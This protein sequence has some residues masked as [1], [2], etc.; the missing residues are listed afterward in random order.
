MAYINI[1]LLDLY[2]SNLVLGS[3][4]GAN[5]LQ[6][7]RNL[8]L[9]QNSQLMVS[10]KGIQC[11]DACAVRESLACLVKM[12]LGNLRLVVS[13][14]ENIDVL[15][16]L[17]LGFN[18][19]NLPLVTIDSSN[20]VSIYTNG[21]SVP[22]KILE[23]IYLH[24]SITTSKLVEQFDISSPNASSKLKKLQNIGLLISEKTSAESGGLEYI[25]RPF[26]YG[27]CVNIY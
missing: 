12:N 2:G 6:M 9:Q 4:A 18:A 22:K 16:N 21:L 3:R 11:I 7:L 17:T 15:D 27:C 19:K 13:D 8:D 14:V 5:I 25:F 20:N 24:E 23:Y 26:C 10:F 1:N